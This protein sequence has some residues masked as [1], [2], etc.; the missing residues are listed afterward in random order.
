MS[1]SLFLTITYLLFN[2]LCLLA[3]IPQITLYIKVPSS[4]QGLALSAW[5]VWFFG[6]VIEFLYAL[7]IENAPWSFVAIGHIVACGIIVSFG[8]YDQLIKRTRKI[9]LLMVDEGGL[10]E[11]TKTNA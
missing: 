7:H 9:E 8:L 6:A 3:Y 10:K 2:T 5:V 11:P 1:Y 4:R